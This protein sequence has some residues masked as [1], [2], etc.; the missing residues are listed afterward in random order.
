MPLS[1]VVSPL[2]EAAACSSPRGNRARAVERVRQDFSFRQG[3][4]GCMFAG[5]RMSSTIYAHQRIALPA[6][7]PLASAIARSGLNAR[8]NANRAA[9]LF[10]QRM[11][12]RL[13]R[14]RS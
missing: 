11:E 10:V 13:Q 14:C 5:W 12:R 1:Y 4:A 8:S 7:T 9:R 2:R 3:L 6:A